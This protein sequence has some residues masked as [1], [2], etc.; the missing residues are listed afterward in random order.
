MQL[1]ELA[2]LLFLSEYTHARHLWRRHETA[3]TSPSASSNPELHQFQLLWTAAQPMAT[4]DHAGAYAALDS[5]IAS[6]EQPLAAYAGE[7]RKQFQDNVLAKTIEGGYS[8]ISKEICRTMLGYTIQQ[9][10]EMTNMLVRGRGWLEKGEY[11]IPC[12]DEEKEEEEEVGDGDDCDNAATAVGAHGDR[13]RELADM[14]EFM[15]RS[16]LNL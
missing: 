11:L 5:C 3:A 8:K 14:V 4:H 7:I 12:E 13:I 1:A 15:E 9:E 6:A 10:G 16:K 2:A